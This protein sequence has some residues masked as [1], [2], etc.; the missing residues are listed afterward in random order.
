[1]GLL[2][3][4][5]RGIPKDSGYR[6][7]GEKARRY[8]LKR[9]DHP[10]TR[11]FLGGNPV[12]TLLYPYTPI[13]LYPESFTEYYPYTPNLLP[14]TTPNLLPDTV[15]LFLFSVSVKIRVVSGKRFGV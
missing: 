2:P 13:P 7:I 12:D 8:Y 3:P 9:L 4:E 14:D 11:I 6:G 1:M 10:K 5:S 15:S